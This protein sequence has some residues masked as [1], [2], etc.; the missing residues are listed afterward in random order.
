MSDNRVT[1][2][3]DDDG[4]RQLAIYLAQLTKEGVT[5]SVTNEISYVAVWLTGGY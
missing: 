3:R 1:F 4:I 5:F 2:Q